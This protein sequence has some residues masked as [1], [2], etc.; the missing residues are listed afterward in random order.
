MLNE[1]TNV[2]FPFFMR[3][4]RKGACFLK[5][6]GECGGLWFFT[7]DWF[8]KILFFHGSSLKGKG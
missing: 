5:T 6:K 7:T 1:K 2:V 8:L 4:S 3:V